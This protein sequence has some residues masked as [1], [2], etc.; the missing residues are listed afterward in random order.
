MKVKKFIDFNN[1]KKKFYD[2]FYISDEELVVK[3]PILS[4]TQNRNIE[5]NRD[6]RIKIERFDLSKYTYLT[7]YG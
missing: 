3:I 4:N 2:N 5:K 1:E 6:E 7:A